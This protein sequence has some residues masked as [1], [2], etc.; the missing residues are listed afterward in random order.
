YVRAG[1]GLCQRSSARWPA[2]VELYDLLVYVEFGQ[3][4]THGAGRDQP[5]DR[6]AE[7]R[8]IAPCMGRS[9]PGSDLEDAQ[10]A[11]R[12]VLGGH[13]EATGGFEVSSQRWI[14]FSTPGTIL[15]PQA[16]LPETFAESY[17]DARRSPIERP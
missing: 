14:S 6:G 16:A 12:S 8:Q 11:G 5:C 4:R 2:E 13:Q 10:R 1:Q 17:D 3:R 9:S 15:S 7:A